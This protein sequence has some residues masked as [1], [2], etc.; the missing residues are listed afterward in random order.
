MRCMQGEEEMSWSKIMFNEEQKEKELPDDLPR[1]YYMMSKKKQLEYREKRN[2]KT[3][4][5]VD[6]SSTGSPQE[7]L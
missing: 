6:K 3:I 5:S 1:R 2:N 4:F 7:V